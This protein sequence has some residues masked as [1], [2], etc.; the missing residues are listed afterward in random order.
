MLSR[1]RYRDLVADPIAELQRTYAE[2]GWP[3]SQELEARFARYLATIR[4]YRAASARPEAGAGADATP[5][6]LAWMLQAF[7][8]DRATIPKREPASPAP[9]TSDATVRELLWRT[10]L[11][12]ALLWAAAWIGIAKLFNDRLDWLTWPTGVLI[13]TIALRSAGRGTWKLG[14]V[15]AAL[16]LAIFLTIAYPATAIVFYR[17]RDPMPFKDVWDSTRDGLLATNNLF[18]LFLGLV[19]AYRL[20]SRKHPAAPGI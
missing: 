18:W 16:T 11:V 3:W 14:L 19:S 13:G 10:L 7:G 2:L 15:A 17:D 8:H 20:A 4:D 6:E 12:V 1:V 5:P 9:V